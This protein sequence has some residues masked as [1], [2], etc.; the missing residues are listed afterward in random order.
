MCVVC[1]F[2]RVFPQTHITSETPEVRLC[3]RISSHDP[4]MS[5]LEIE[6]VKCTYR[7]GEL[8]M[9]QILLTWTRRLLP[10]NI[11]CKEYC[12]HSWAKEKVSLR[13]NGV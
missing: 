1:V 12:L 3:H 2:V 6:N 10:K 9:T 4:L 8:I 11:S 7:F 13:I 5:Q